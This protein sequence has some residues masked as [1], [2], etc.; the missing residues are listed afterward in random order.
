MFIVDSLRKVGS[1]PYPGLALHLAYHFAQSES[2]S[3]GSL[4]ALQYRNL[5]RSRPRLAGLVPLVG[6]TS[7]SNMKVSS[8]SGRL[9]K[10]PCYGPFV[11]CGS[12]VGDPSSSTVPV[13]SAS[14]VL[15]PS[16]E[17][18]CLTSPLASTL[19]LLTGWHPSAAH[20]LAPYCCSQAGTLLPAGSAHLSILS[21]RRDPPRLRPV[22]V[23]HCLRGCP[24][25][26]GRT[27]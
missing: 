20:R 14:T 26:L 9:P 4:S 23:L 3:L 6:K 13:L 11:G 22:V 19:L 15:P 27:I 7:V 24:Q 8:Q 12:P 17:P 25:R 16:L 10:S 21:D 18:Y 1:P 2:S 5:G